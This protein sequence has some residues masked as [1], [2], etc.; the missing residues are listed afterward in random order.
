[1]NENSFSIMFLKIIYL[2]LKLDYQSRIELFMGF[3]MGLVILSFIW[4]NYSSSFTKKKQNH[5]GIN[6]IL[7]YLQKIKCHL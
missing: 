1:M 2:I 5:M 6:H 3:V 7:V 4:F